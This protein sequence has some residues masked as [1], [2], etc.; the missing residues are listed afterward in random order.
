VIDVQRVD[1]IRV[2]VTDIEKAKD[3]YGTTTPSS[4]TATRPIG[5]AESV[6]A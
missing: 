5:R 3:F 4:S 6:D 1:F 2:L